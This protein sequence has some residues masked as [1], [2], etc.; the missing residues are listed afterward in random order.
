MNEKSKRDKRN[1][2]AEVFFTITELARELGVTPRTIRFYEDKGLL[3]PKRAGNIRIYT[4][5]D[6]VRM[7]VIQRGKKLGFSLRDIR[8]YLD[9]YDMD[10][11]QVEQMRMLLDRVRTRLD[12]LER[13]RQALEETIA[14]LKVMEAETVKALASLADQASP[15]D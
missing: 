9:L 12:L 8:E 2:S 15:A 4:K 10:P 13:Q 5:R 14:E 1:A 11:T 7:I 6:R 3:S